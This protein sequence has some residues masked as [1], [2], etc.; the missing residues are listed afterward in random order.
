[1]PKILNNMHI[2]DVTMS[3]ATISKI[4]VNRVEKP[5]IQAKFIRNQ[6]VRANV[7]LPF[8]RMSADCTVDSFF[9]LDGSFAVELHNFTID[10]QLNI[11]RNETSGRNVFEV[12]QCETTHSDVILL[13]E[14]N[15]LLTIIRGTLQDTMSNVVKSQIC[16]TI[17]DAVKFMDSQELQPM[18]RPTTTT[19][20][21][22]KA[23][24]ELGFD[25]ADTFGASLCE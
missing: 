8:L 14:E 9:P 10:L 3:S 4:H 15:S 12:P 6:G 5:T 22:S 23:S 7:S 25:P 20:A 24:D 19:V 16:E 21:S 17:L 13:L 18:D 11:W 1:M 2:P